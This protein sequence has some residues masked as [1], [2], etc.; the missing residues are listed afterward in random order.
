MLVSVIMP[1]ADRSQEIPGAIKC[2]LSQSWPEKELVILDDGKEP[3]DTL[4]PRGENIRSWYSPR[5]MTVGEKLNWLCANARGEIIVRFD[6]DDW[7][8][9]ERIRNQ[10]WALDYGNVQVTGYH[11]WFYYDVKSGQAWEY[12]FPG[13]KPYASGGTH[14]FYRSYWQKHPFSSKSN[15]EDTDFSHEAKALGYLNSFRAADAFVARIHG[16]NTA[17]K[18][19]MVRTNQAFHPMDLSALPKEFLQ[20]EGLEDHV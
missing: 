9:P 2:F 13:L 4:L 8:A 20:D 14:A 1:T 15:G 6:D 16:Q 5:K 17:V 11:D 12:R 18:I 3:I 7:S 19:E 10:V